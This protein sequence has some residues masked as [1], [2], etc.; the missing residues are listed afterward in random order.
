MPEFVVS[1]VVKEWFESD[2]TMFD[3]CMEA[4]EV[5]WEAIQQILQRELTDEQVAILAAGPLENLLAFHGPAFI[6]RVEQQAQTNP[7][8]NHL[9]GGVWRQEMDQNLWARI[10]RVRRNVW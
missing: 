2:Q 8:F 9:L 4:P 10:E 7:R 6:D 3:A 1:E 5:A